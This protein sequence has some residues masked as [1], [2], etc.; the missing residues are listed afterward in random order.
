[1]RA[2]TVTQTNVGY[3]QPVPMDQYLTP[4]NVGMGAVI[5]SGSPTYTVQHT[6]DDVFAANYNPATG[7]WFN[8][9]DMTAQTTNVDGNYAFN[10]AAIR[11]NVT[12]VGAPT[13]TVQLTIRQ[14]G[15]MG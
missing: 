2:I 8:Q 14:A 10:V 12:A 13:D 4:F 6:F 15:V 11:L 9:P 1:M 7:T 5:T 3:T